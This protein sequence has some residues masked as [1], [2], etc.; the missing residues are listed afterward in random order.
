MSST[1]QT[2]PPIS[3]ANQ[4]LVQHCFDQIPDR[5]TTLGYEFDETALDETAQETQE[6]AS[7]S[8]NHPWRRFFT[9][10]SD[11]KWTLDPDALVEIWSATLTAKHDREVTEVTEG[12][13]DADYIAKVDGRNRGTVTFELFF[14]AEALLKSSVEPQKGRFLVGFDL[15][16]SGISREAV[17]PWY[18]VLDENFWTTV[19]QLLIE[20]QGPPTSELYQAESYAA[21]QMPGGVDRTLEAVTDNKGEISVRPHPQL[22]ENIQLA[23]DE[24][25][26]SSLVKAIEI[27]SET[28]LVV[29]KC[30]DASADGKHVHLVK[31]GETYP[32]A[33]NQVASELLD[34]ASAK[35]KA[36]NDLKDERDNA[37]RLAKFM[38]PLIGL[39]AV[40]AVDSIV[41][42]INGGNSSPV[43]AGLNALFL[44]F[45]VIFLVITIQPMLE[46]WHFSWDRE[47]TPSGLRARVID[48]GKSV[49]AFVF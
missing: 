24:I 33:D 4:L 41:G 39:G 20:N 14:D 18:E 26:I 36:Y 49:H 38:L 5:S 22:V 7:D 32:P 10:V 29:C 43:I 15:P 46:L 9:K 31:E 11:G 28:H 23:D 21:T 25:D 6:H 48:M 13:G 40:P 8:T 17:F 44:L 34:K 2:E 19:T 42:I 12:D 27:D 30:T 1:N 3:R 47:N 37:G 35:V 16:R 45:A